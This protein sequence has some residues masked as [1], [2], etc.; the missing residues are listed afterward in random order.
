MSVISPKF[1]FL[2][3]ISDDVSFRQ[4]KRE[5][6]F[7]IALSYSRFVE[8]FKERKKHGL[9]KAKEMSLLSQPKMYSIPSH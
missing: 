4:I 3:G 5:C 6:I 2:H 8:H 7:L 1:E 9:A